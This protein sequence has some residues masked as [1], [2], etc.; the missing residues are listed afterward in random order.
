MTC[1]NI[2]KYIRSIINWFRNED[3]HMLTFC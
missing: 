3:F 1:C 2:I